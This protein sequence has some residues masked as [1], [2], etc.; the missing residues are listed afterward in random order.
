MTCKIVALERFVQARFSSFSLEFLPPDFTNEH[1][2]VTVK[3]V[4]MARFRTVRLRNSLIAFRI[5][6]DMAHDS[7]LRCVNCFECMIREKSV[8][9]SKEQHVASRYLKLNMELLGDSGDKGTMS[10]NDELSS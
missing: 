9:F 5:L 7:K 2:P 6:T 8:S 10:G 4:H 3:P 1:I